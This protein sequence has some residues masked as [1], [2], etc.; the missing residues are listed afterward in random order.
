MILF[1]MDFA[2][3][4]RHLRKCTECDFSVYCIVTIVCGVL[5]SEQYLTFILKLAELPS[6]ALEKSSY[7][8][9]LVK[10]ASMYSYNVTI[11]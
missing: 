11:I 9:F 5:L 6:V 10:T 3:L 4:C 1:L 8:S 7:K 2:I